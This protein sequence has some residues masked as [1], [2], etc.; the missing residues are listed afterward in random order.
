MGNPWGSYFHGRRRGRLSF[1]ELVHAEYAIHAAWIG[2]ERAERDALKLQLSVVRYD[3]VP[4]ANG[5]GC[6]PDQL[7]QRCGVS[8][9]LNGVGEFHMP[10]A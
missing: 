9:V 2:S 4:L 7:C 5:A 6:N 10:I 1:G 8:C 3:I